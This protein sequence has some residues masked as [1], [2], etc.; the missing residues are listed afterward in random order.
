MSQ[1]L[2]PEQE[3]RLQKFW[4]KWGDKLDVSDRFSMHTD[5][6]TE[7]HHARKVAPHTPEA[8]AVVLRHTFYPSGPRMEQHNSTFHIGYQ[9]DH[10]PS[11][12]EKQAFETAVLKTVDFLMEASKY[13]R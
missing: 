4:E 13:D 9:W 6:L 11:E 1:E 8:C 2:M 10:M 7:L 12:D 5:I 3:D